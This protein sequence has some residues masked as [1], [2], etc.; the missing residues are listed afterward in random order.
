MNIW[1]TGD[2]ITA[3]KLN[4]SVDVQGDTMTGDLILSGAKLQID[5]TN[6]Y[7]SAPDVLKTD[8]QLR[9]GYAGAWEQLIFEPNLADVIIAKTLTAGNNWFWLNAYADTGYTATIGLFRGSVTG[10][11]RFIICPAN[12]TADVNLEFDA[13]TGQL[14]LPVAGSGAGILIGGDVLIYRGGTDL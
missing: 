11:A 2:T 4:R 13:K 14:R 3:T 5:D 10:G 12:G 6:L 9:I 1:S 7:R 8:D